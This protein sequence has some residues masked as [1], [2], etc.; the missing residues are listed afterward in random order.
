MIDVVLISDAKTPELRALTEQAIRTS[1]QN[2]IVV[3]TQ[4]TDYEGAKT[5][6][7]H[8]TFGYNKFLNIGARQGTATHIAF[9]N[10]DL[11]F[12]DGWEH[13]ADH[14][15]IKLADSASPF[16]PNYHRDEHTG[17]RPNTGVKLG[18]QP[19]KYVAGWCIVL[20]R[21]WWEEMGGFDESSIFWCSENRYCLQIARHH[22]RH[23]L[24][25]SSIVYH[26]RSKT[27]DTLDKETNNRYT[28]GDVKTWNR[29]TGNNL[30]GWGT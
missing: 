6:H 14:M 11:I 12:Q 28:E 23:V 21:A 8:L 30:F 17:L 10:N 2:C 24:D 22:K 4:D 7:P 20:L 9:C 19:G 16:C 3:E 15:K 27:L 25:T 29:D 26:L 13:I 1:K 18:V 5:I